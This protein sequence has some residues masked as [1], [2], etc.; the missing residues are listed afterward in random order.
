MKMIQAANNS[1]KW[2]D[3]YISEPIERIQTSIQSN[4]LYELHTLIRRESHL[5]DCHSAIRRAAA[6]TTTKERH[7]SL[8]FIYGHFQLDAK[9]LRNHYMCNPYVCICIN[10]NKCVFIYKYQ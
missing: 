5:N 6:A 4:Q 1:I 8:T 10:I 3:Y 9:A 7:L 2:L